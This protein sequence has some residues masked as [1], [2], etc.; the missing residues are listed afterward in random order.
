MTVVPIK[1]SVGLLYLSYF[2]SKLILYYYEV[3]SAIVKMRWDEV[4]AFECNT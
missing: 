3:I 4:I 2:Q 1:T